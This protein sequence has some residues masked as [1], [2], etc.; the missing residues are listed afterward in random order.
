MAQFNLNVPNKNLS[1]IYGDISTDNSNSLSKQVNSV[2]NLYGNIIDEVSTQSNVPKELITSMII[3]LSNGANNNIY[4]SND[5]LYRSGLFSLSNKTAKQIL[6]RE[7]AQGRMSQKEIDYLSQADP[8][9][10]SYLSKDKGNKA[11]NFHWSSDYNVGLDRISDT[12]N[13]WNLTNPKSSIA[14]GTIWLGQLWDKYSEQTTD[15]IDKV[16]ITALLPYDDSGWLSGN[17]F[18]KANSWNIDYTSK[19]YIDKIPKPAT[20]EAPSNI[21][22]PNKGWVVDSLKDILNRNGLLYIQTKK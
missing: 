13:S 3:A 1:T 15:P 22:N 19:E 14:I 16:I 17:K 4:R 21:I 8:K 18:A 11:F 6:A 10:A 5:K 12:L 20:K 9:I 2:K 7:M